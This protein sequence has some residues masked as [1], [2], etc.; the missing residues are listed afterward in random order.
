MKNF[1]AFS[2]LTL[3]SVS[4]A[5]YKCNQ[6]VDAKKVVLFVDANNSP[7]E[8]EGA[9]KAACQ[10]GESFKKIPAAGAHIDARSLTQE[11]SALAKNNVAVSSMIV[12]GHDGGGSVHGERGGVNKHEIIEA[13]RTGYKEKP[14][15]LKEMKSIFMWGCWSMGPSEVEVW[16]SE[17]PHI[18]LAAGFMDMGPLN[19]TEASHSVLN[20]LLV[21]EKAL[22][23]ESD[24]KKLKRAIQGIPNINV[25]L[26]SVYTDAACGDKLYYKTQGDSDDALHNLENPLF[27]NGTHFV[28]FDTNFSCKGMAKQIE[29]KR[30]LLIKYFYGKLPLPKDGPNSPIRS[31]YAFIRNTAK[32]H[33]QNHILNGD[34]V[35]LL[36]FYE[37][38]KENFGKTFDSE[39]TLANKEYV[40]LN[41]ILKDAPND[42]NTKAFRQY[43]NKNQDKYFNP[44]YPNMKSKSRKDILEMISYL[45]GMVKQP[46]ALDPKNAKNF[47]AL[48][49]MRNAMDKYLFQ[50]NTQCMD[51]MEWHEVQSS[52]PRAHCPI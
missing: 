43:L 28:D 8:V 36:R 29:E 6:S 9:A 1:L 45:D 31:I 18:K 3:S 46:F 20:G 32:C 41:K 24:E 35:F 14:Q 12:S 2:L 25:T 48:K 19:T 52:A 44:R 16:K 30:T 40:A 42:E 38:V 13:L 15:L 37:E 47:A 4:F 26:A 39:I 33:T 27:S 21:K 51:F 23:Q 34:R 50:L 17:L 11:I 49:K 10:R 22:I 7:K 5:Q